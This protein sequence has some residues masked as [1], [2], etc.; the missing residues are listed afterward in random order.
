[1][2]RFYSDNSQASFHLSGKQPPDIF[3]QVLFSGTA[4]NCQNFALLRMFLPGVILKQVFPV[5][6]NP[7]VFYFPFNSPASAFT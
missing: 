5:Q 6:N 1:M 4:A 3:L 2:Q 7:S